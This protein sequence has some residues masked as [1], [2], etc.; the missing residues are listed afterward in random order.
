MGHMNR[1]NH[2]ERKVASQNAEPGVAP[3]PSPDAAPHQSSTSTAPTKTSGT[4]PKVKRS[5][6]GSTWV[7]LILG[8]LL[9]ILL[10]VF[11]LQNQTATQLQFFG[12]QAE[13]PVGVGMLIAAIVGALIMALVGG[14]RIIQL[15]GQV[16]HPRR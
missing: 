7:A 8:A 5:M 15:R 13:F 16:K 14:V 2:S 9:L 4:P 11:I 10:L 12:W 1:K 6:A 3:T